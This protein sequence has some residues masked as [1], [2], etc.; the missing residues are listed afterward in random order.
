MA[1]EW[2]TEASEGM[3]AAVRASAASG[4]APPAAESLHSRFALALAKSLSLAGLCSG[5]D[6]KDAVY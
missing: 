5:R 1:G 3:V 4:Q 2:L 6:S